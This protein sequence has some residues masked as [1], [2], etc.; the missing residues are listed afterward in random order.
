MRFRDGGWL[1]AVTVLVCGALLAWAFAGVLRGNRPK[2]DGHSIESYGF[3][4]STL[5]VDRATL[6]GSGILDGRT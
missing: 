4:L 3:D 5:T 6:V 1:I 2:G